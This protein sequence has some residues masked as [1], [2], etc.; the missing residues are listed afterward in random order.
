MRE[1][2]PAAWWSI[3]RAYVRVCQA[4]YHCDAD[5]LR[6]AAQVGR[7]GLPVTTAAR[8]GR[9]REREVEVEIARETGRGIQRGI[10]R[11]RSRDLEGD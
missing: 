5:D 3:V 9:Q 1:R 7:H 11:E 2:V 6:V 4:S 8:R 10:E